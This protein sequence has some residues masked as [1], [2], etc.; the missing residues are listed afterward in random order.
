MWCN[1]DRQ[2]L[3]CICGFAETS[4]M[5]SGWP[6]VVITLEEQ[7]VPPGY[8]GV[9]IKVVFFKSKAEFANGRNH[10]SGFNPNQHGTVS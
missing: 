6:D 4:R 3:A 1:S 7:H 2:N 9:N 8:T 5:I 10:W